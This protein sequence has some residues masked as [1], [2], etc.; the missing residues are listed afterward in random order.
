MC[1]AAIPFSETTAKLA[2]MDS[3]AFQHTHDLQFKE[4]HM[5]L[6]AASQPIIPAV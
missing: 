6:C 5:T 1:G 4:N 2:A 3:T